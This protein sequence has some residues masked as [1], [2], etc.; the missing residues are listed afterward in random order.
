LQQDIVIVPPCCEVSWSDDWDKQTAECVLVRNT[1]HRN[2]IVQTILAA[3]NYTGE[4][5][6]TDFIA[7]C[8]AI[9]VA[10][11]LL[12]L[13][14]R[15]MSYMQPPDETRLKALMTDA[16]QGVRDKVPDAVKQAL[17]SVFDEI[18]QAKDNYHPSQNYFVELTLATKTTVGEPLRQLLNEAAPINLFMPN[19]VLETLPEAQPETFAQLKSAVE[20]NKV[21]FIADD[22]ASDIGEPQSLILLPILDVADHLL[23]G[24]STYREHLNISPKVYGRLTTGITPA[25]PQLLKLMG[26]EGALHFAPLVG[27]RIKEQEQSKIVWQGMDNTSIDTLVRYPMDASTF[28]SFFELADL[29][30]SQVN[31]DIVP[32]AVLALFPGQ[33]SGWLDILRRIN[34][35]TSGLGKFVDI[36][37]YFNTTAYSGN[38]ERYG[39]EKYPVNALTEIGENPISRWHELYRKN[40]DRIVQ[41]ALE[42]LLKLLNR[43]ES[44]MPLAQQLVDAVAPFSRNSGFSTKGK[45]VINPLNFPRKIYIDDIAVDVPPLGYAFIEPPTQTKAPQ[46][47]SLLGQFF[48]AKSAPILARHATDDIGRGEKR[49]VYILE[50]RYFTAKVDATTGTLRSIFTNRSRFNQLSRQ[51]AFHKDQ[52]YSIQAADEIVITKTTPEIGQLKI[53]GRLVL[54]D[55]NIAA[56]YTE[57]ITIRSQS[58]LLEFDLA[59]KPFT[60]FDDDR[61]KS[62]IAV[63]YAWNDDTFEMR[64]GLNDGMHALSERK[65][66]YAPKVIDLRHE[67]ASLTFLTEGLPFHRRSGNRQLDTLLMVKEE[68]QQQFRLGIAVNAKN[69]MFMSYD[70]LLPHDGFVFP[71]QSRPK[72]LSSWLF[73]IESHNVVA[74]YWEPVLEEEKLTGYMVYLQETAGRRAHFALRSFVLPKHAAAMDLLGN[75]RKTFKTDADAVLIDMH[76][77]ELL[78][79]LVKM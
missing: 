3:R 27:W 34:R 1:T 11:L 58:R 15:N 29:F 21:R 71:V 5:F 24:L 66:L 25:L 60:E 33:K 72:N 22:C 19:S 54:S 39:Y 49:A 13:Y 50:N 47:K 26:M 68:S 44:E 31:Q 36:N 74:L 8:Y 53:T 37:E 76:G 10:R 55:G 2:E 17:Q 32:T 23:A 14:H 6:D 38:S 46:N 30:S 63:R 65:H 67:E 12:A 18:A 7:D 61:W 20:Q 9:A 59:L 62:Y 51:I 69:P 48:A 35:F 43:P 78:P 40:T 16:I 52:T 75:E 77:H 45:I 56:R 42:T 41:S 4:P 70:F 64:G 28:L 73:Q 79:L 57:T